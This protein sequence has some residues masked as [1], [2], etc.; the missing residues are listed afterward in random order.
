MGGYLDAGEW[1]RNGSVLSSGV[2]SG[3]ICMLGNRSSVGNCGAPN[4]CGA[5]VATGLSYIGGSS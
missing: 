1:S 3:V 4:D 2:G 5:L